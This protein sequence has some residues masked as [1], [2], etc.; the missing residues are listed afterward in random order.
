MM[1]GNG[2]MFNFIWLFKFSSSTQHD[3]CFIAVILENQAI[4]LGVKEDISSF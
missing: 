3:V 2:I 1:F 4:Y